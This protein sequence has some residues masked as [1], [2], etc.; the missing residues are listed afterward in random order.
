MRIA[1]FVIA[2]LAL[3][4]VGCKRNA[5]WLP[6]TDGSLNKPA[7]EFAADAASRFPY[8]AAAQHAGETLARAEIGYDANVVNFANFSGEVWNDVEIWLNRSY[9]LHLET[10]ETGKSKWLPFELFYSADGQRFPN[11]GAYVELVEVKK[12]GVVYTVPHRIGG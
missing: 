7:A 5:T 3:S 4:V 11:R 9:V 2:S 10:V 12:D 6:N 8:P 1:S